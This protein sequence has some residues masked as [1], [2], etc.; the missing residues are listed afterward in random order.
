M[1]RMMGVGIEQLIVHNADHP[2]VMR[3]CKS[4]GPCI[5][6]GLYAIV[7][8]ASMLGGV[9]RMTISLVVIMLELTGGYVQLFMLT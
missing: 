8:A 1:G 4:S 3:M 5:N 7:G 9:T 2:L 6:P